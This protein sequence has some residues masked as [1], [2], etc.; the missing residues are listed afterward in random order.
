MLWKK[1][2]A[3]QKHSI[4]LQPT[5]NIFVCTLHPCYKTTQ[6][7]PQKDF[8]CNSFCSSTSVIWW[9][10]SITYLMIAIA[11]IIRSISP[12]SIAAVSGNPA[13][14]FTKPFQRIIIHNSSRGKESIQFGEEQTNRRNGGE[15]VGRET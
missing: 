3:I 15:K 4:F 6:K 10:E 9:K 11:Y 7:Y 13:L 5:T 14:F 12:G 1:A 2:V 8:D